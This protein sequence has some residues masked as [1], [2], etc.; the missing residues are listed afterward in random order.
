MGSGSSLKVKPHNTYEQSA[1]S[2]DST[3]TY[4]T[5][6]K[7]KKKIDNRVRCLCVDYVTSRP[8]DTL[9]AENLIKN[10]HM[11]RKKMVNHVLYIAPSRKNGIYSKCITAKTSNKYDKC[12]SDIHMCI[13]H[14]PNKLNNKCKAKNH[15]CTCLH[16]IGSGEITRRLLTEDDF[17]VNENCKARFHN[18]DV[19][20]KL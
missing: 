2:I 4:D 12:N 9:S 7:H 20:K 13:C 19:D 15:I 3:I 11:I 14:I 17:V 5:V 10:I 16:F 8:Y 18:V 1:K 6:K